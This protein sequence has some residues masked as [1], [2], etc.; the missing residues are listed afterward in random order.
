MKCSVCNKRFA[1][2]KPNVYRVR[3]HDKPVGSLYTVLRT[4]DAIDCPRC[5]CQHLLKPRE[6]REVEP[7]D[8]C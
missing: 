1:I 6:N 7:D 2:A 3:V 5:G 8:E 4:F